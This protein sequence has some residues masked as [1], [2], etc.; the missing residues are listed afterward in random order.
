V[1]VAFDRRRL[2]EVVIC[3]IVS[4]ALTMTFG[5]MLSEWIGVQRDISM[6]RRQLAE[7]DALV[8]DL[9]ELAIDPSGQDPDVV[10]GLIRRISLVEAEFHARKGCD[11]R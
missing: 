8:I 7:L 4:G 1:T 5:I 9:R 11:G 2:R 3:A 6:L 10:E